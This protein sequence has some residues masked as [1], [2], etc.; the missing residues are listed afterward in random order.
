MSHSFA[1]Y[2][3][4]SYMFQKK[5]YDE[6]S[7]TG[8]HQGKLDQR[9][10]EVAVGTNDE[11]ITSGVNRK[12]RCSVEEKDMVLNNWE[13]FTIPHG[14]EREALKTSAAN[15]I[16]QVETEMAVPNKN[17]GR[18]NILMKWMETR[19]YTIPPDDYECKE[20]LEGKVEINPSEKQM[21]FE[22]DEIDDESRDGIYLLKPLKRP[23]FR[24]NPFKEVQLCP[25]F[26]E[27][28]MDLPREQMKVKRDK[29]LIDFIKVQ[30]ELSPGDSRN[31]V[32]RVDSMVY[33][34]IFRG[35]EHESSEQT[36]NKYSEELRYSGDKSLSPQYSIPPDSIFYSH[37]DK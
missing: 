7:A 30:A 28:I 15:T 31:S 37:K 23:T 25:T 20:C 35:S 27:K 22:Q 13:I 36:T 6:S 11:K 16:H 5:Q 29:N 1:S 34:N 12:C 24:R 4:L 9:A 18:S 19:G 26:M 10:F 2:R 32:R 8:L 3:T 14:K 17:S 21:Y 33:E